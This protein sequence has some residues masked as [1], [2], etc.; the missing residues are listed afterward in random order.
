M[1]PPERLRPLLAHVLVQHPPLDAGH[2]H[3]DQPV[4]HVAEV[5]VEVDAEQLRAQL[6]VVLEQDVQPRVADERVGYFTTAYT[7]LGK[8]KERETR[9][10]HINRWFLEK[11]DPSLEVSPPKN[12]IV[13]YIEHTTPIRYRRF[14]RDGVLCWN[15]AFEKVGLVN[16]EGTP[17]RD[18]F[19]AIYLAFIG[20]RDGP[21]AGWLLLWS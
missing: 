1:M 3:H 10:R 13:F 11:A 15:K 14:V 20:K 5:R 21:R 6:Q 8:F 16:A 4:D 2:V 12:P 7:D 17:S 18:A 9:V 19:A